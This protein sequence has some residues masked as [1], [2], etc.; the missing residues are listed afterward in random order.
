ML[1]GIPTTRPESQI[2]CLSWVVHCLIKFSVVFFSLSME[3]WQGLRLNV[4]TPNASEL[5]WLLKYLDK[6]EIKI[7]DCTHFLS[8]TFTK[9]SYKIIQKYLSI[10]I[11]FQIRCSHSLQWVNT[12]SGK[13]RPIKYVKFQAFLVLFPK[14]HSRTLY[15]MKSIISLTRWNAFNVWNF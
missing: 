10:N 12:S 11:I 6:T 14:T 8:F 15:F 13:Q 3:V 1:S 5:T 7:T 2:S 4:G 9:Y